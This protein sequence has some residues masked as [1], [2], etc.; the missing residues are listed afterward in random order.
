MTGGNGRRTVL[1]AGG[2]TGG[3]LTPA[4]AIAAT[5]EVDA[6]LA[7]WYQD[8]ERAL[9]VSAA[10]ALFVVALAVALTVA[11]AQ[12][13]RTEAERARFRRTLE[14]ALESM[15]DGFVMFDAE[16]RLVACNSRYRDFYHI[17]APFI[18]PGARFEDILRQ[19]DRIGP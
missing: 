11:L 10:L 19:G 16:D 18:V 15:S 4:L 13:E 14:S 12:R 8:T 6:A 2:G 5:M 7:G 1:I 3:H 9:L 17:S